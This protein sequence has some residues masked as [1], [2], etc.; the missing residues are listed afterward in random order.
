VKVIANDAVVK[1]RAFHSEMSEALLRC[2]RESHKNMIK[3]SPG[4]WIHK[5]FRN[6]SDAVAWASSFLPDSNCP[7]LPARGE[8]EHE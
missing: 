4:V 2:E 7:S 3:V 1:L 5:S 8:G 6:L